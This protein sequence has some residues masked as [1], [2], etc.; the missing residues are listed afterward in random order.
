MKKGIVAILLLT[1]IW[2]SAAFAGGVL[3]GKV[4]YADGTPSSTCKV[5][6][7]GEAVA[8]TDSNGGYSMSLK[9]S[10][11]KSIWVNDKGVWTGSKEV[12]DGLTL[13]LTAKPN[14]EF[15]INVKSRKLILKFIS[16]F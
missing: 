9:G 16:Y 14:K 6:I 7:C 10:H 5:P 4:N 15:I 3:L 11:V 2:A 12:R 1:F 13:N 8:Y